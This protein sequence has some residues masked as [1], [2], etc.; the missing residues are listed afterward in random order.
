MVSVANRSSLAA[1]G[2][3]VCSVL[4]ITSS[5]PL[6]CCLL[7]LG[8]ALWRVLVIF[9]RIRTP[10]YPKGLRFALGAATAIV[11]LLIFMSF[12]TLN[13]L[14]AGTALLTVMGA[15]KLLESRAQR[16]DG[17]VIGVSLF[18]LLAACLA[19]QSLWR[20]PLYVGL[21]WLACAA[22]ALVAQSSPLFT[23]RAALKLS[24]RALLMALPLAVT[25]FLFF[26][27]IAG[28]FFALDRGE[29]ATTGLGDTMAPGAIDKLVANYDPA[30]RVRFAGTPPPVDQL[31]F[32]G[33]VLNSFDGFAWRRDRSHFY[34]ASRLAPEGAAHA[35]RVTLEPTN[36]RWLYALDTIDAAPRRDI[37]LSHD[38]MLTAMDPVTSAVSYDAVSHLRTRALTELSTLGRRYETQLPAERNPRARALALELRR[39]SS[40]DADFAAR[41]LAWFRDN[42]L[43]YTLE[44]G[45][46]TLDSVDTT[47]FDNKRGFCG[48]FASAYA[49]LMR[50]AG[51]PARVVTGYLGGEW[52][53][54]GGYFIVRQSD[55][56]AWTEVW[57][58]GRG[59]TRIDPT[60]VVAPERL[61]RGLYDFLDSTNTNASV[62][63]RRSAWFS[64]LHQVWDGAN[65]WW[66]DRVVEFNV[67]AQFDFLR[68]LGFEDASWKH[69]GVAFAAALGAWIVWISLA[70]R[71]SVGRRRPDRLARAWVRATRKLARVAPPRSAHEG[72]LAYAARVAAVRPELEVEVLEIARSYATLRFGMAANADDFHRELVELEERIRRLAIER[73]AS[74]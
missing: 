28:Q 44:P 5:A 59:W 73:A 30:F 37:S 34:L 10:R 72:P 2:V 57:I 24:A 23:V 11:V 56:H 50:A 40:S 31:Y 4:I 63:L 65:Q 18:I 26:P 7:A 61:R 71:R 67:R 1:I 25:C 17:I 32:R 13:G 15:L 12:R 35:Y 42:G 51:V 74:A 70:L 16:D 58:E 41:A 20:V 33:P 54:I 29:T 27:R 52:N 39:A 8:A 36:Q 45:Q 68:L 38:R 43:E 47:L 62:L 9:G 64:R 46:T 66:Q 21:A 3:F 19:D 22:L 69:L 49:N 55:A 48:H 14:G 6:W 60:G 53:P